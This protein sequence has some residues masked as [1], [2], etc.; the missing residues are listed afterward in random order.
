MWVE[1]TV[2]MKMKMVIGNGD[3]DG[4]ADGVEM[5]LQNSSDTW[6]PT[7][8]HRLARSYLHE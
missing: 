5:E 7:N 3:N 8:E 4:P 6:K 1:M 2:V